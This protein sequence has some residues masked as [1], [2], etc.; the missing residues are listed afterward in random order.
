MFNSKGFENSSLKYP[1]SQFN[2]ILE[3]PPFDSGAP[4]NERKI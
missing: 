3:I 4:L 1:G 2:S